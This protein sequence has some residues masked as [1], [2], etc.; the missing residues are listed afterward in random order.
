MKTHNKIIGMTCENQFLA[1]C[2]EHGIPA[3][4]IDDS[5]DFLVY[6]TIPIEVKSCHLCIQNGMKKGKQQ[7]KHGRFAF[8]K[9]QL[10][11]ISKKQGYIALYITQNDTHFLLGFIQAKQIT[12]KKYLSLIELRQI[13][14]LSF[15]QWLKEITNRHLKKR[16]CSNESKKQENAPSVTKPSAKTSGYALDAEYLS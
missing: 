9:E 13:K 2:N 7:F 1:T 12:N 10:A 15:S 3:L 11:I 8:Q 5:Y 16:N 14:P 4:F 6:K